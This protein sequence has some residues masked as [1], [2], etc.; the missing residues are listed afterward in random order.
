MKDPADKLRALIDEAN[1]PFVDDEVALRRTRAVL[2]ARARAGKPTARRWRA[3][4]AFAALALAATS[5]VLLTRYR[6]AARPGSLSFTIAGGGMPRGARNA[7]LAPTN[8]ATDV[9]FSDGS[10]MSMTP[11]SQIDVDVA[12]ETVSVRLHA[13][14]LRAHVVHREHATWRF[15]AGPF[16]VR[17]TGT[18]F[19]TGWDQT[20]RL[21]T[22]SLTEGGVVVTGP[23]LNAS[24]QI[25]RAGDALRVAV[26]DGVVSWEHPGVPSTE[27]A[28]A[29]PTPTLPAAD[30]LTRPPRG[31]APAPAAI[32]SRGSA[33]PPAPRP[34]AAPRHL[35]AARTARTPEWTELAHAERHEE[36]LR[37][38]VAADYDAVL[39]SASAG[40]L[41]LLA[42]SARMAGAADRARVALQ[43]LRSRFP[44]S[45]HAATARFGLGRLAFD[46]DHDLPQAARDFQGYLDEAPNGPLVREAS[47]RLLEARARLGDR[48]AASDAAR[49]YL[50]RFPG[51][52]HAD[53]ARRLLP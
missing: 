30:S 5:G 17:V 12:S 31:P 28:S 18:R 35:A 10:K 6:V 16:D 15:Q 9:S 52:P 53:L 21:F 40:E 22:L 47:G 45:P 34:D 11:H 36:A 23:H 32:P 41:L 13:G 44:H 19:E 37:A 49:A 48:A 39:G 25:V 1:A 8:D 46:V 29:A 4:T 14:T 2:I 33:G 3:V 38:A 27:G 51:G 7:H 42:D 20:S 26:S 50:Q 43:A 24:G